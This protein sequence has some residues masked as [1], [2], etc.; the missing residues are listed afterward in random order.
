MRPGDPLPTGPAQGELAGLASGI[1]A[2]RPA[3]D[4]PSVVAS[5]ADALELPFEIARRTGVVFVH[6]IGTQ[7]AN[8]TFLDW[9][10]PIVQLL[11]DWRSALAETGATDPATAAAPAAAPAA[12]AGTD[13]IDDPVWTAGFAIGG[14]SAPSLE[15]IIP[16]HAGLPETTWVLTEAWWAAALRPP[17][18]G[19]TIEY[20]SGRMAAVVSGIGAGYRRRS[21]ALHDLAV[22]VNLIGAGK[23]PLDWRLIERLD[24]VQARTFGARPIGLLVA[25]LGLVALGIYDLLRRIPIRAVREF[26]AARMIDSFIVDWFGDLPILIDDP[27]QSANVRAHLARSIDGLVAD[28]C[29]AVVI[30]AHSGGA[31]VSFEFLLD[32]AYAHLPVDKLITLGQG[33]GLAW[34]LAAEPAVAEIDAGHRLVGNLARARPGL[35]WVDVWATYDPAPAGPLPS[36]SGIEAG[37]AADD[38]AAPTVVRTADP[39]SDGWLLQSDVG[40]TDPDPVAPTITVES[41]PV[42]NQMNVLTDHGGYW[43]NPEGFLVPLVRH[44]D[45][46]R[47]G[48]S[49]SRFYRDRTDRARRILWR[50]QRVGA[51]AAWGWL[52]AV[53]T[54]LALVL[55]I[56]LQIG[57]DERLT[58]AGDRVATAWA[59]VPGSELISA[60]IGAI[61]GAVG[62]V[63]TTL[64]LGGFASWL[65]TLGPPLLGAGLLAALAYA[66]VKIG[67]G[68][69]AAWDRRERPPMHPEVPMLPPRDGAASEALLLIGGVGGFTLATFGLG[70]AAGVVIVLG[71]A[72]GILVRIARPFARATTGAAPASPP[73][74]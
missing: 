53:V 71:A 50:R 45:A 74:R 73:A 66:L 43:A 1:P 59:A 68:R 19:R 54:G 37:D 11:T 5:D 67:V 18:L 42:T 70:L 41:R 72:A 51:L 16:A 65:A 25:G 29:D 35:R 6:G 44:I 40:A 24:A 2:E 33:L 56:V 14:T 3:Q 20:L 52:C 31:L 64:G 32:P 23:E 69:W 62:A 61:T 17:S 48:A 55:L 4:A 49:A 10:E 8:E 47:G 13:R 21:H 9:A 34:R 27:V 22:L 28:G 30:V 39:S 26:A 38:V 12:S 36:R 60:P 63:L 58:Q 46:A 7:A 57:G 15:L